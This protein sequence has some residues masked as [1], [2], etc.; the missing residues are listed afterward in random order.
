MD[1]PARSTSV[2]ISGLQLPRSVDCISRH[3]GSRRADAARRTT[4]DSLFFRC[5]AFPSTSRSPTPSDAGDGSTD[6]GSLTQSQEISSGRRHVIDKISLQ[7]STVFS[8]LS[9]PNCLSR[10]WI[11][12]VTPAFLFIFF[13]FPRIRHTLS[14]STGVCT[15]ILRKSVSGQ[16]TCRSWRSDRFPPRLLSLLDLFPGCPEFLHPEFS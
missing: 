3:H 6:L 1:P 14:V 15:S 9:M 13:D 11:S 7:L 8:P 4:D 12:S 10:P 2:P 5:S 16:P